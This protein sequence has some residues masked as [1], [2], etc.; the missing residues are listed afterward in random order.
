MSYDSCL[1]SAE[2]N[3]LLLGNGYRFRNSRKLKDLAEYEGRSFNGE[4]VYLA[5]GHF[6]DIMRTFYGHFQKSPFYSML[7]VIITSPLERRSVISSVFLSDICPSLVYDQLL[8]P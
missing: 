5:S 4:I 6:A 7:M 1:L 8:E 2:M 3:S